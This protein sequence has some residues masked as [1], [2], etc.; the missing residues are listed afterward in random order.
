VEEAPIIVRGQR[1]RA[2]VKKASTQFQIR[3]KEIYFKPITV[4]EREG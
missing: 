3:Q 2:E 4:E 1:R